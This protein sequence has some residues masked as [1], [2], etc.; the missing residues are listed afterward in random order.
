MK[1]DDVSVGSE[2]WSQADLYTRIKILRHL[3][4]LDIYC[5]IALYGSADFD[6]GLMLDSNQIA[7]RRFNA[8][9]RINTTTR[10]LLGN[11]LFVIKEQYNSRKKV[12]G[13]IKRL[14]ELMPDIELVL[15][16]NENLL[17]HETEYKIREALFKII[18]QILQNIKDDLNFP[19]NQSGLIFKVSD[20]FDL[21][22]IMKDIALGG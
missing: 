10:Q 9:K 11:S 6:E 13:W 2:V 4:Q 20:E 16:T 21:D 18:Y 3:V 8:L 17:T 14:D 19:L 5:D 1:N 22:K 12:D 15:A 7:I